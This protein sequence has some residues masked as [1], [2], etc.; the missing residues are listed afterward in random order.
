LLCLGENAIREIDCLLELTTMALAPA[1][2][3][4]RGRLS[5]LVGEDDRGRALDGE[6]VERRREVWHRRHGLS[7]PSQSR[8]VESGIDVDHVT[9]ASDSLRTS[10]ATSGLLGMRFMTSR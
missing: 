9:R 3:V 8:A 6:R 7:L 2:Q 5:Q 4:Q 1:R 10:S